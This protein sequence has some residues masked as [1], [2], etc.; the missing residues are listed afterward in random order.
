MTAA[1]KYL[2]IHG[3][4]VWMVLMNGAEKN[5]SQMVSRAGS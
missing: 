2:R 1:V 5:R 4:D 3:H